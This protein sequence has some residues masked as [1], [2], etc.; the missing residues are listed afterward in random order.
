MLISTHLERPENFHEIARLRLIEVVEVLAQRQLVKKARCAGSISVPA[1][2]DSF[3]IV[4]IPNDELLQGGIIEMKVASRAQ[5]LDCSDEHQI[6]CAR[7]E[8]WPGWSN[9]KFPGLK[10]RRRLKA[11][12]GEMRNRIVT[13]LRHLFDLI[14]NHIVVIGS[15][16]DLYCEAK[17]NHHN[18]DARFFHGG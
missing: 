6:R 18:P 15:E 8:T 9:E 14:E 12:L 13:T 10:M 17:V 16:G 2:P 5:S 3:A 7:T 11:D 4:L 1:A